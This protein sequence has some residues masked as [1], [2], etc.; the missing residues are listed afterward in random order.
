[1]TEHERIERIARAMAALRNNT[2][3]TGAALDVYGDLA[4]A[5]DAISFAAAI[6]IAKQYIDKPIGG[7]AQETQEAFDQGMTYGAGALDNA[8]AIVA[9]LEAAHKPGEP[10]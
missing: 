8:I 4:R 5:A 9:A 6:E 7:E 3:G 1:M 10:T 2:E